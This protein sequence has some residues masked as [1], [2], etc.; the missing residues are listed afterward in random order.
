MKDI[1]ALF[2]NIYYRIF[3]NRIQMNVPSFIGRSVV[4]KC[5]SPGKIWM[6][7]KVRLEDFSE[8]KSN[9]N[10][11]IG[12][13][14]VLNKYSRIVC[15][16]EIIIGEN[17]VIARFVSILDHDHKGKFID[18]QFIINGYLTS[19]IRIGNNVWI[20]DKVSITKGVTIGNNVIIGANSV[21]TKDIPDNSI[22]AGVPAKIIRKINE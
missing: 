7:G 12:N 21:V 9:G 20:G 3:E 15:H 16:D 18:N 14:F 4:L 13:H 22:A 10:L 2:L 8:L 1:T 5:K 6:K 17:V 19:P 11:T